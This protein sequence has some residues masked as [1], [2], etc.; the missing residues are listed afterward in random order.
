MAK[1]EAKG[2]NVKTVAEA[3]KLAD[4]IMILLPDEM[5]ADVFAE[6]INKFIEEKIKC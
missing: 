1:A 2:F 3:T 4:V 6:E 5:Q